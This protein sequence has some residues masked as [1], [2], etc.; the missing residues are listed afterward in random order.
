M[1]MDACF[2]GGEHLALE[3]YVVTNG[4]VRLLAS[5]MCV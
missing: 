2:W 5:F 3:P 1:Q 4:P